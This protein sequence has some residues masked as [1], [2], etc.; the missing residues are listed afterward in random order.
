EAEELESARADIEAK[1]RNIISE[2]SQIEQ[3]ITS[4]TQEIETVN[5][6]LDQKR[7]TS[8]QISNQSASLNQTLEKSKTDLMD[9]VA[10]EAR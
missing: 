6:A 2:I 10:R 3:Q 1:N 9:L 5:T 7:L 4:L 8:Q